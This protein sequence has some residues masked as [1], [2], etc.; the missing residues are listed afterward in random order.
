MLY[1]INHV[2]YFNLILPIYFFTTLICLQ[3]LKKDL[4]EDLQ[5]L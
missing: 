4:Q 1:L 2:L 3:E 5:V